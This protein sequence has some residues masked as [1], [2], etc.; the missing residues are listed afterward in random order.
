MEDVTLAGHS[1]TDIFL[2]DVLQN[3]VAGQAEV[4]KQ[5][6]HQ[7]WFSFYSR[8]NVRDDTCGFEHGASTAHACRALEGSISVDWIHLVAGAPGRAP[9]PHASASHM[10]H[11][12][13][14]CRRHLRSAASALSTK[15][16]QVPLAWAALPP[17]PLQCPRS[18]AGP[19][20]CLP[21]SG[22]VGSEGLN[23]QLTTC[24]RRRKE[25]WQSVA[26]LLALTHTVNLQS[27]LARW[28]RARLWD[29]TTGSSSTLRSALAVPITWVTCC[30]EAGRALLLTI[31]GQCLM[32]T[33]WT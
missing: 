5:Q 9:T 21:Q 19:L 30:P 27:L 26:P 8:S 25:S 4:F 17:A 20:P 23:E 2:A 15:H 7:M 6:L 32:P 12:L 10:I 3:L 28:T 29:S 31:S 22:A 33:G 24:E 1:L 14:S 13:H 18:V 11:K 16:M